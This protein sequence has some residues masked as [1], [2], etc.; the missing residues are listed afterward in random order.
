MST[1][2]HA[3]ALRQIVTLVV[4]AVAQVM[5]S[6]YVPVGVSNRHIHLSQ[7]DLNTLFDSELTSMRPLMAGNFAA[8]QTVNIKGPKGEI[9]RVRILGPTRSKTQ[10]E[11]SLTDSFVL[12]VNAPIAESGDLSQAAE[13]TITNPENGVSIVSKSAIV[14]LRHI[15]LSPS[16]AEKHGIKD[17]QMVAV[18]F[19]GKR[20][21]VF[22]NTLVRVQSDFDDE[23]HVDTD[24][25]NSAGIRTGDI[26]LILIDGKNKQA[27]ISEAGDSHMHNNAAAHFKGKALTREDVFSFVGVNT[28]YVP[29]G[30]PVTSLARDEAKKRG[31]DIRIGT[32]GK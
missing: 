8:N 21:Q 1:N 6:P 3:D 18:E 29:D 23:M 5:N 22:H 26:G 25:A 30:I 28:L 4:K 19:S 9:K 15:H 10:A 24:E 16:Y 32:E 13:I 17:K 31:I 7:E 2:I 20:G 27:D 14:A 11:I 12:G